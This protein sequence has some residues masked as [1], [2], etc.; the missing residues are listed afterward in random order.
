MA[1]A[2]AATH[3]APHCLAPSLTVP[4]SAWPEHARP[5]VIAHRGASA[6]L[7]EHTLPAYRLALDLGA[8]YI[9]PDLVATQDGHLIA[10]HSVDLNIT[11]DVAQVFPDRLVH[12]AFQNKSGYWSYSFTLQEIQRL[13]VKQRLPQARPTTF[14]GMFGIPT[15]TQILQLVVEWQT[16]VQPI[17]FNTT[18]RRRAGPGVYAEWKDSTWIAQDT[19]MDLLE[20]FYQHME[21]HLALWDQ[22]ILSRLCSTKTLRILEYTLPPLIVQSFDAPVLKTFY[23]T[24]PTRLANMMKTTTVQAETNNH[25]IHTQ[26]IP[27]TILL[28]SQDQCRE[29]ALW[30]SLGEEYRSSIRGLGP[31][32][33]CCLDPL[34]G[35]AFVERARKLDLVLHPYTVRPELEYVM[36]YRT[37]PEPEITSVPIFGNQL[38]E[39][40]YLFCEVQVDGVFSESVSP[41]VQA[42]NM[43]CSSVVSTGMFSSTSSSSSSSSRTKGVHATNHSKNNPSASASASAMVLIVGAT[44]IAVMV[45]AMAAWTC[46][47]GSNNDN[48]KRAGHAILETSLDDDD[49]HDEADVDEETEDREIL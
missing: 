12:S 28:L 46:C 16:N 2:A 5:I 37:E 43:D 8:D 7:P 23:E 47:H 30:F 42:A 1:M 22:A 31:D 10:M 49:D 18:R 24:W 26:I 11:T 41:A 4:S 48:T 36:D 38:D 6:H 21:Q 17:D 19:K 34:R 9:E 39:L 14:D 15:L 44:L 29:E 27:P 35:R 45:I 40:L 3:Q 33:K 25:S 32:K 20:L 13:K